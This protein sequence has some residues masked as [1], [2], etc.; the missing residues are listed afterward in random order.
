MWITH[1]LQLGSFHSPTIYYRINNHPSFY[2]PAPAT[3][4]TETDFC[5]PLNLQVWDFTFTSIFNRVLHACKSL[6]LVPWVIMHHIP[7]I[8]YLTF[9]TSGQQNEDPNPWSWLIF[10]M[11]C[12]VVHQTTHMDMLKKAGWGKDMQNEIWQTM[13]F[14]HIMGQL[15]SNYDTKILS[16]NT[17]V[18]KP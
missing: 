2:I 18:Y 9:L 8:V 6:W 7:G 11:I 12:V 4:Y 15:L 14:L 16:N 5:H 1:Y 10:M 3:D 13:A 17:D